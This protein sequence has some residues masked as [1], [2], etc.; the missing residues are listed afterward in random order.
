[1][2]KFRTLLVSVLALFMLLSMAGCSNNNNNGGE[3]TKTDTPLVVGYSNFSEKFSPFFADTAYDQDVQGMTQI[4]LLPSDRT[5]AV[6]LNAMDGEVVSYNGTDYTYYGPANCVVTE[7]SDGT[8]YYDFTL[9]DGITF[10]DGEPVTV[11]DIIFS[12]YVLSDPTYDGSSTFWNLPID[13]MKE[14]RSGMDSLKNLLFAAGKDNTDF[15]YWDEATQTAFWNEYDA[16]TVALAQE[17]TDYCIAAGYGTNVSEAAAAWGF[18]VPEGGTVED[19]AAALTESYGNDI[20][21]MINTE[22]AGSSVDDLFPTLGN[23]SAGITTGESVDYISGIQ[24][25]GDN[26]LR[27]VMNEVSAVALYQLTL[28]ISPAHYYGDSAVDVANNKFGFTKGDLSPVKA[29]TT[30]PLGAGAYKFVEYKD[31][32]VYFEANESFYLGAPKTKYIQFKEGSDA[33]KLD[34]IVAGTTDVSDP[35]FNVNKANQ[36]KEYNGGELSGNVITTSLVDNLGYGYIGMNANRVNIGGKENKGSEESKALRKALATV[37]SVY[38]EL[39]VSS[40][41]GELGSVINYPIS[42]TS[43]AAPQSTDA[44]YQIAFSVDAEGNEIYADGMSAEDRYAAALTAAL[45]W[46]EKAGYTV[47]DGVVTAAPAGGRT[48]FEVMIPADGTGD[49]PAFMV[50]QEA[51]KA[52]ETIGITLTV[53]DLA[54][55]SELW[56]AL[57]AETIDMWAAAWG[58][59]VDPDMTQV[60]NSANA[61]GSNHYHIADDELDSLMADALKSSDQEYRKVLYKQCLDIIVDWAVEIPTYQRKNGV[62]FSTERVNMDTVV[63]DITPFYG[64]LSEIEKVELN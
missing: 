20:A 5:G 51:S 37:L 8:V 2:K 29:K 33:D 42:N 15:T 43:W 23:Y 4:A 6:L 59:T 3:E 17:I 27:V 47:T 62:I 35:S 26:T 7:N 10:S 30:K 19:F 21:G 39:S 45:S 41:Y 16:A 54:N 36:I 14:Y 24:K 55:S 12:M 34:G 11:D 9:K 38:R 53:K 63:K 22:N 46:F 57:D 28:A 52:L 13:G 49:H 25:T 18:S 31:G 50:L 48:T 60:Y 56:D 32:I 61:S 64:W 1:M 44:D 40:Y 58:S